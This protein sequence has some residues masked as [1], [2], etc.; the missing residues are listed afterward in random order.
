MSN[1]SK[2]FKLEA[3]DQQAYL[4]VLLSTIAADGVFTADEV[5]R[6]YS[7]FAL[8]GL[9]AAARRRILDDL[10]CGQESGNPLDLPAGILANDEVRMSLAKD[11]LFLESGS[12]DDQT[13]R[14]IR[15]Y[16]AKL[17]L[18]SEQV[19]VIRRFVVVE[20]QILESLGAGD[21]WKSD[22]NDWK[23]LASRAAAVG[24][25]LAALNLAGITGLSAVGITSGLAALGS[26]SGL[27]VLG[28]NPMTAGIGALILGG[29][30]VKKIADYALSRTG[31]KS[32][33]EA[34]LHAF[35]ESRRL[36]REALSA[37]L[38]VISRS[39]KREM[40]LYRDRQERRHA[41]KQGME[42]ALLVL[43]PV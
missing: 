7:M 43:K 3:S 25:P 11:L 9:D 24:V 23:E 40:L 42:G 21:E 19:D 37:D 26:M 6:I 34:Q 30:A 31:D 27:V 18:S 22:Q 17:R 32:Q 5:A 13:L 33:K 41:L 1:S 10:I 39:R 36:A 29:V 38:E 35:K 8:F 16:L 20:N 15:D 2:S 14:V 4:E 12:A 28:L